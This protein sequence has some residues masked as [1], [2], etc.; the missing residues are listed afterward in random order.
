M[1]SLE[2]RIL[3]RLRAYGAM[4][5][6]Q[7]QQM[8]K[9]NLHCVRVAARELNEREL[10]HISGWH[11]RVGGVKRIAIYAVGAG[12]NV[13]KEDVEIDDRA[14]RAAAETTKTIARLRT[15][16]DPSVFDPFRVLRAQVGGM[17]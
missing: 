12:V 15:T 14:R 2:R 10:V 6:F 13:A 3:Y 8:I 5:V 17:A 4:D 7:L 1:T 9:A 16:V 11:R